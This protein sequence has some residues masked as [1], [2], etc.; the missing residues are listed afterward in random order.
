[1]QHVV[2]FWPH[3]PAIAAPRSSDK[4]VNELLGAKSST[5]VRSAVCCDVDLCIYQIPYFGMVMVFCYEPGFGSI[6]M[7]AKCGPRGG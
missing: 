4:L 1:M 6:G 2:G 3:P 5:E 7:I